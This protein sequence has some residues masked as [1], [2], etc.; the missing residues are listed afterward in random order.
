MA[1]NIPESGIFDN[2]LILLVFDVRTGVILEKYT[3]DKV[4]ENN[5]FAWVLDSSL[6][7]G[8]PF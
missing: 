8:S 3:L 5:P 6:G 1:D 2:A 4:L 7:P